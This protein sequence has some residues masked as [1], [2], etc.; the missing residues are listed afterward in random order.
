LNFKIRLYYLA[1]ILTFISFSHS[2]AQ[3]SSTLGWF[4]INYNQGCTP[5]EVS[6][7][8]AIPEDQVPLFQFFGRDD[9]NPV[10]WKDTFDSLANTYT[11]PGTF[12]VYLTVQNDP[13]RQDS[14]QVT[15]LQSE[16][17]VFELKD[18]EGNGV[19]VKIQDTFY[20]SHIVDFGDGTVVTVNSGGPN[21]IHIYPDSQTYTV[22]LTGRLVNAPNNCGSLSQSFTPQ[23]VILPPVI[24]NVMIDS[25]NR[26]NLRFSLPQNVNYRLEVSQDNDQ[27]FQF[28][29]DLNRSDT[30]LIISDFSPDAR[31][32]C[33]RISALNPCG[34]QRVLSNV[35]CSISLNLLLSNNEINLSWQNVETGDETGYRISRNAISDFITLPSGTQNFDDRQV[36]CKTEYCYTV[37]TLYTDGAESLTQTQCG[38]A[39]SADIPPVIEDLTVDILS[40]GVQLNWEVTGEMVESYVKQ[41]SIDNKLLTRDTSEFS[42]T[43]LGT[44]L[45]VYP[46]TCYT[47]SYLDMCGNN[48]AETGKI[49]SIFLQT[50][51]NPGGAV[52]LQWSEFTGLKDSIADYTVLKFDRNDVLLESIAL[53]QIFQYIDE[54]DGANDQIVK[55]IIEATPVSNTFQPIHSNKVETARKPLLIFPGAFTPNGDGLNDIFKPEYIFIKSYSLEIFN[56]WGELLFST[57]DIESGWDGTFQGEMAPPD[58]YTFLSNA[59]DF[60]GLKLSRSGIVVLLK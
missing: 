34:G 33:F 9:P 20:D 8:T 36:I 4:E 56:R 51:S 2:N 17:P 18:C 58:S 25:L 46:Q 15:V 45:K 52:F 26:I 27:L 31:K 54:I 1:A 30:A 12:M 23:P 35:V 21:P 55:Y 29:K 16:T 53:G 19:L 14:L 60:R 24:N 50:G 41:Y 6:V 22:T 59:E 40:D 5:L 7:K 32:Y 13:Q 49:C 28:F 37:T 43:F 11:S 38:E 10:A 48:S 3:I 42:T 57:R 39:F 44:D 47:H